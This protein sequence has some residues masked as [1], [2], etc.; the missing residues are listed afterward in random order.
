IKVESVVT[1][2]GDNG[3]ID[4][5]AFNGEK[6][7]A[8][9]KWVAWF[10]HNGRVIDAPEEATDVRG[11]LT[12]DYQQALEKQWVDSIRKK[13]KVKVNKGVLKKIGQ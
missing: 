6:P 12:T 3:I 5:L 2:K 13:Y 4:H 7:E 1:A 11:P 10:G 8:P 9:G